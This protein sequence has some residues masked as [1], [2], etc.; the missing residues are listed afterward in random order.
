MLL[1]MRRSQIDCA[2]P[3]CSRKLREDGPAPLDVCVKCRRTF[4]CGKVCQTADW[5]R[6]GGHKAECKEF[7]A[8]AA[9]VGENG[10]GTG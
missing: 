7:I 8:A 3:G 10:G 4:Y 1:V 5:K 9:K 6:K 2:G